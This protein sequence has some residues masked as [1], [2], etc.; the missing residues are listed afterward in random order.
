MKKICF[1]ICLMLST[2]LSYAQSDWISKSVG[3]GITISFPNQPTYK[4]AGKAGTYT[5]KTTSSIIILIVQY[6]VLPHYSEFVKLPKTQQEQL[7][8]VFLDNTIKGVITAG[9]G[10]NDIPYKSVNI[11]RY[12]GR[13]TTFRTVNPANGEDINTYYKLL[14]AFNK[15][16]L[17]QCMS[18]SE[19]PVSI[20][21]RKKF[22]NSISTNSKL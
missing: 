13:E 5:S 6:D 12:K 21:E 7:I 3:S 10:S 14:Y 2:I 22:F 18:L 20:S 19:S 15:V 8:E 9:T 4:L 17:L 11:G 1:S 16:Y